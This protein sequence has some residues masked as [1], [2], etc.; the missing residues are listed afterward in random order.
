MYQ[1]LRNQQ[2][3]L[4]KNIALAVAQ[5]FLWGGSYFLLSVLAA[6]IMKETGWTHQMVYGV[7]SLSLLVAGL[8]SSSV[9]KITNTSK[10]NYIL[11]YSGCTMALGLTLIG[12]AQ[13]YW[14]FAVGWLIV[15]IG[16]AMGLYDALFALLGKEYGKEANRSIIQIT[17]ISGFASTICWFFI[18]FLLNYFDWRTICFLYAFVLL[19]SIFPLHRFAF[20]S[21]HYEDETIAKELSVAEVPVGIFKS[22]IFRLLLAYFTIG[23]VL[24]TG[25][26]I[27][28]IDILMSKEMSLTTAVSI[29]ALLGPSQVGAR[30]I[31]M[32]APKKTA[33]KT[34]L[35]A[36]VFILLGLVLLL[37][38][39]K[40]AFVGVIFFGLGNGMRSILKGT[41]PLSI[42][43]QKGY[44]VILGKL[45]GLPLVTQAA[46]PF[47]GALIIQ[48][49]GTSV[50]VII[51]AALALV[52]IILVLVLQKMRINTP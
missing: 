39:P 3:S 45:A 9:G 43:G 29:A 35:I 25:V 49:F 19:I 46:T 38:T 52:N 14:L 34:A 20:P 24:M 15:G 2:L 27:Q 6:P 11:L 16:M 12:L 8:A 4:T 31:D 28:L 33:L 18:S 47:I 44:A 7:L 41:L 36:S 30:I 42:F 17:L 23:A 22:N 51:L 50:F 32:I 1:V 37:L 40:I 13:P 21:S 26:I 5:I 48:Q 10:N